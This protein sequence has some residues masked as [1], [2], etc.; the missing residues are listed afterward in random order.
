MLILLKILLFL[1]LDLVDNPNLIS[2]MRFFFFS[3]T[4][5]KRD[6]FRLA[7]LKI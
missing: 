7:V 5:D 4:F 3:F 6:V 1:F 2:L